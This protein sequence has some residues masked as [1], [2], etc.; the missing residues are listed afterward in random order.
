MKPYFFFLHSRVI[1]CILVYL[2]QLNNICGTFKFSFVLRC[3][4]FSLY[5]IVNAVY[6]VTL[7]HNEYNMISLA[8]ILFFLSMQFKY[9]VELNNR[10]ISIQFDVSRIHVNWEIFDGYCISSY[11]IF[12]W[13]VQQNHSLFRSF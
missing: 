7:I 12:F 1:W 2:S 5:I 4:L 6:I 3:C 8:K 13:F 9:D 11:I 10:L